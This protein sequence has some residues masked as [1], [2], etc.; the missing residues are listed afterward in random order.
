M[1]TATRS[2][3]ATGWNVVAL[4]RRKAR[5]AVSEQ[6]IE[7]FFLHADTWS[8]WAGIL[9]IAAIVIVLLIPTV[10]RIIEG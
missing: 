5:R 7:R 8:Y 9:A 3:I 4:L 6:T 2:N 10:L 1:W